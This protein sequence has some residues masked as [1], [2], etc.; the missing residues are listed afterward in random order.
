MPLKLS[1]LVCPKPVRFTACGLPVASSVMARV[2]L[3]VPGAVGVNVIDTEQLA[4][5]AVRTGPGLGLVP[6][7]LID[8]HFGERGRLPRLLSGVAMAPEHLGIG[9]DENAGVMVEDG[10]FEVRALLPAAVQVR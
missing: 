6:Q 4:A 5:G 2:P 3:R 9:L 7:T 8:M 1:N 10:G